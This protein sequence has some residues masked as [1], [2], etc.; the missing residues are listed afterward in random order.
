MNIRYI[1]IILFLLI[2]CA[3]FI[4]S[5]NEPSSKNK[6]DVTLDS[7]AAYGKILAATWCAS[8]HV[9]PDPSILPKKI[10]KE[11]VLP[12]MGLR[13]GFYS[14]SAARLLL[15]KEEMDSTIFPKEK[16]FGVDDWKDIQHYYITLAPDSMQPQPDHL[17]AQTNTSLFKATPVSIQNDLAAVCF[18]KI[19][20]LQNPRQVV[21]ADAFGKMYRLNDQLQLLDS[22]KVPGPVV[23]M[24]W[25]GTKKLYTNIGSID[26][27]IKKLGKVGFFNAAAD[28]KLMYQVL[29]DTLSRP[30]QTLPVD[31]NS[32]GKIDY[33]I[34]EFGLYK[35]AVSWMEN[36]G[37]NNY[38]KHVLIDAPGA[39]KAIVKDASKDGLPDIWVLM[40]Q[41]DESIYLLLNKGNSV[42]ESRQV[43]R[44]SPSYGSASFELDDFN[45]DGYPDILY[46]CGDNADV[47]Q[48]LKP[49]HGVYIFMNDK[50]NYFTQKYFYPMN[51]CYKAMAADFDDDGD[52]DIAAI[53]FFADYLHHPENGFIFLKND[54]NN[55]FKPF[56]IPEATTGRR[57]CMDVEDLDGDKKPDIVLGNMP[58][59]VSDDKNNSRWVQSPALLFLKNIMPQKNK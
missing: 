22:I 43:L 24:S 10:W 39:I 50:R 52:L 32:D 31:L 47:S 18:V 48:V 55:S 17:N 56:T 51:G 30:T 13:L 5:C 2:L 46:T 21:F 6:N 4:F 12:F 8:C 20:T 40:A 28:G 41:G 59:P 57:L 23:D 26:P 19:D 36:T 14:V 58:V 16:L 45:K 1:N 34:C 29:F 53:A 44:F 15:S 35:G 3:L 33:L 54:G 9:L 42:F 27:E 49:Y 7:M 38:T 37:N 11:N 25:N